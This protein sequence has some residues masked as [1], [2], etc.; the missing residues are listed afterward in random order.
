MVSLITRLT[1]VQC[2]KILEYMFNRSMLSM[3]LSSSLKEKEKKTSQL[4]GQF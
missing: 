2:I 1:H 3:T 4:T